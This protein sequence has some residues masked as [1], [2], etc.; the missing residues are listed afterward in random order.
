MPEDKA[1]TRYSEL[2]DADLEHV[3]GGKIAA[4]GGAAAGGAAGWAGR[5]ADGAVD[6][7]LKDPGNVVKQNNARNM[8]MVNSRFGYGSQ[9]ARGGD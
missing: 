9:F 8:N 4:L 3:S 5:K 1:V 2:P 7:F 6:R